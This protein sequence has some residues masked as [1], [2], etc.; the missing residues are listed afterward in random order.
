MMVTVLK[1]DDSNETVV[2]ACLKVATLEDLIIFSSK[3]GF[4]QQ[5]DEYVFDF[6]NFQDVT[7]IVGLDHA[8]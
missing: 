3:L 2:T 1:R 7:Y 5:L 4:Q 6:Q 8:N